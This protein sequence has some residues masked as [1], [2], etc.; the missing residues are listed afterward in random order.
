MLAIFALS[1]QG[2]V[3]IANFMRRR[4]SNMLG[5]KRS[6]EGRGVTGVTWKC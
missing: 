4:Q 2:P 5:I 1:M 3:L 6:W